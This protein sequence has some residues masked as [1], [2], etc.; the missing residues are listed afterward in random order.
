MCF[1]SSLLEFRFEEKNGPELIEFNVWGYFAAVV[2]QTK[3]RD[4]HHLD[5]RRGRLR[6]R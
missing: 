6:A 4:P 5:R 3:G 2:L 1:E